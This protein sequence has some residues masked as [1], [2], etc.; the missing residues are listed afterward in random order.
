MK[1]GRSTRKRRKEEGIALLISIFVLLLISV[2]AIALIVS[3]GTE[4][5]LAGNYRSSTG[6]YYAALA[7][8]EEARGRLS[9]K[10]PNSFN[11]T[12][13]S[14][15]PSPGTTIAIGY[16]GYV[17]NPGPTD[18]ADTRT[19]YPDT[20]YDNEFGV[21]ALA[22]TT[23]KTTPSV[24]NRSPLNSLNVPGPLYKWVRINPVSEKSLQLDVGPA[25]DGYK[26]PV[27]PVFYDG[28]Q[29][30]VV[31][32]GTQVIEITA[33]AVLPNGSQKI[34]QY[35]AAPTPVTLPPFLAALTLS[36]S[37]SSASATVAY[38][39][40]NTNTQF[41]VLGL[42]YDCNG[43][44]DGSNPPVHA[45]GVFN[46]TDVLAVVS[47]GNGG[48]GIKPAVY[49][50]PP[51]NY[52]QGSLASPDVTRIDTIYPAA[53]RTPS[54]L[55][56]IVQGI[57]QN[58]DVLITPTPSGSPPYL[59]TA[60]GSDLTPLGMSSSNPLT[61]VVNGNLDIS[62]WSSDGYGLLVVT[63][64]FTYDPDTTWNGIILVIGQGIVN[65]SHAQFKEIN[66]AV[67]VAKTHDG[68]NQLIPGPE[69]VDPVSGKGA[70]VIFSNSMQGYGIR[71]SSCWIQ[72]AQPT[73]GFK[74]L[75]FHEIA[76]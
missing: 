45:I 54:A 56:A 51:W 22:A 65:G 1:M 42:N 13:P 57:S 38:N 3:S 28:S 35:L 46:S 69:L 12:D 48:G 49:A 43:T 66:G 19:A 29:L 58:A 53:A 41:K 23:P 40:P 20:E 61:V 36:G 59:G 72:K 39:S 68:N 17:L 76:Q 73:S 50:Y 74:I 11:S 14:F 55:D 71:Y 32:N 6:V 27:T 10:N 70:S 24:W 16:V 67:F 8:I 4:S 62:N 64:T 47:G 5:A 34:V 33:L 44:P 75:S 7:G 60:T 18:P 25:Y 63:G 21:G 30:N 37:V 26:D 31:N 15:M 9:T 2:V 52:Y